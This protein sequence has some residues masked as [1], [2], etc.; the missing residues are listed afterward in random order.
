[1]KLRSVF[2]SKIRQCKAFDSKGW[3]SPKC[4]LSQAVWQQK[5]PNRNHKT[6]IEGSESVTIQ[7]VITTVKGCRAGIFFP[8]SPLLAL[9]TKRMTL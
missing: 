9:P 4:S 8:N 3:D 5:G 2:Q 7:P 1:M 6:A